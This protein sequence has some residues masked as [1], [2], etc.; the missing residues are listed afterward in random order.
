MTDSDKPPLTEE[1]FLKAAKTTLDHRAQNVDE[2]VRRRLQQARRAAVQAAQTQSTSR[3]GWLV[4]AGGFAV[5]VIAISVTYY[6]L[7]TIQEPAPLASVED[8][9][10]LVAPEDLELYEELD[11]YQWLA[12]EHGDVG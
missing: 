5:L 10:I 6:G 1:Q 2:E 3:P 4:P 9:P 8:V 11:F 7:Q 12:E